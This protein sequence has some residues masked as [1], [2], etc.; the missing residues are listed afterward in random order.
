MQE[1]RDGDF[2]AYIDALQRESAERLAL[3]H[4]NVDTAAASPSASSKTPSHLF[5]DAPATRP[6]AAGAPA[7]P[8]ESARVRPDI[9]ASVVKALVAGV[10][11]L[12][13]LLGWL[14]RGGA[15]TF[16]ISVA[17]LAYAMP[18]LLAAFRAITR[19]PPSKAVID[20]VFG[21]TGAKR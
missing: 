20:Q 11:G 1:P 13:F 2:V 15:L 5:E 4:I 7:P 14:G 9:D 8:A 17:L 18:R 19:Q 12:A 21:R 3:H 10:V 16:L 6:G